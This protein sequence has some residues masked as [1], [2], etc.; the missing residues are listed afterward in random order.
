MPACLLFSSKL[1]LQ[2]TAGVAIQVWPCRCWSRPLCPC[3]RFSL[4]LPSPPAA[5]APSVILLYTWPRWALSCNE[6]DH[7]LH[8][9]LPSIT[10]YRI[11]YLKLRAYL[12]FLTQVQ[13]IP[14]LILRWPFLGGDWWGRGIWCHGASPPGHPA[15]PPFQQ[16]LV[17]HS[18]A[19]PTSYN[20]LRLTQAT[21]GRQ[22]LWPYQF[23][24]LNT[25][26]FSYLSLVNC[27]L[28]CGRSC[29]LRPSPLIPSFR[30]V[31]LQNATHT[32]WP[33]WLCSL[34]HG[35]GRGRIT[36]GGRT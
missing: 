20:P 1:C 28:T 22:A 24:V 8:W 31:A 16:V 26:V 19:P 2:A 21:E 15:N 29:V 13:I 23:L 4:C 34:R 14:L 10:F 17:E 11:S 33:P 35:Q 6:L 30:A 36:G 25:A 32:P 18:R 12:I 5:T 9:D 7:S 3:L 27:D